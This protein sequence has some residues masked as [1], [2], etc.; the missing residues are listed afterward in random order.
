[1]GLGFGLVL[2]LGSASP[3][4]NLALAWSDS[5]GSALVL[6]FSCLRSVGGHLSGESSTSTHA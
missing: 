5:I 3:N 4:P 1:L 2:G 6:S